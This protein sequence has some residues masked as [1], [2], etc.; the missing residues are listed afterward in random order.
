MKS[1]Y[2]WGISLL[3]LLIVNF[4]QTTCSQQAGEDTGFQAGEQNIQVTAVV[5]SSAKPGE[6][7][8]Q[9]VDPAEIVGCDFICSV[10]IS[11]AAGDL[12]LSEQVVVGFE[13]L[14]AVPVD[15]QSRPLLA[16][17]LDPT[18]ERIS[19]GLSISCSCE[20]SGANLLEQVTL[21][22]SDEL[23]A[24]LGVDGTL[25]VTCTLSNI[26]AT[27]NDAEVRAFFSNLGCFTLFGFKLILDSV[28]AEE[29][30]AEPVGKTLIVKT[31]S[32]PPPAP[33]P[34][35]EDFICDKVRGAVED[36]LEFLNCSSQQ[37]PKKTCDEG[38]GSD[39]VCD[40]TT[41][42]CKIAPVCQD[43]GEEGICVVGETECGK[44][45]PG[46]CAVLSECD[47]ENCC[48]VACGVPCDNKDNPCPQNSHCGSG[49]CRPGAHCGD[50]V[51]SPPQEE[52]DFDFF[53]D[54]FG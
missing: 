38:C 6:T 21:N 16:T 41:G 14:G 40:E 31:K 24:M 9:S 22:F 43:C 29:A 10:T 34:A 37:C 15:G 1:F 45:E 26:I 7:K 11:G 23:S 42:C 50:S 52:C 13:C 20:P 2:G 19:S 48:P 33:I 54:D 18:D 49:C 5:S 12:I 51:I 46:M 28:C 39:E 25:N 47:T 17:S 3:F 4:S 44:G 8:T 35:E 36:A 27:L 32:L 53:G 30:P